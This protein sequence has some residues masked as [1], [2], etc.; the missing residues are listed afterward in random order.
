MK[1][2]LSYKAKNKD[3]KIIINPNEDYIIGSNNLYIA[4]FILFDNAVKY[5]PA[6]KDIEIYFETKDKNTTIVKISNYGP[7][8]LEDEKERL[9]ERGY[10]GINST[11][12]GQGIRL[13][14]FKEIC[15]KSNYPYKIKTVPIN[16]FQD[17]FVVSIELPKTN[18]NINK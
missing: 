6:N 4:M 9:T 5:S 1:I 11:V 15:N 10:R 3:V 13:S 7:K 18:E 2:L 17:M 16:Q 14:V 12:T 8:I